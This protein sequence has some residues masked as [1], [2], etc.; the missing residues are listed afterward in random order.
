MKLT[1]AVKNKAIV[2]THNEQPHI[3]AVFNAIAATITWNGSG[4]KPTG[5]IWSRL[6][7]LHSGKLVIE[8]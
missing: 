8:M 7:A 2:N 3:F 1:L 6:K 4:I 5:V